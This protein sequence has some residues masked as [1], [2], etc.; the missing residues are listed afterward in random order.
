MLTADGHRT[1][2]LNRAE[3]REKLKQLILKALERPKP[4]RATRP[5][6]GS[7]RRRLASKARRGEVKALRGQVE[8][9]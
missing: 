2:A 3:A 6:K 8:E 1:Q 5:T 7:V 4:R 9:D